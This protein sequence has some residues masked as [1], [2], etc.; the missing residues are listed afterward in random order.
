MDSW[1]I[2]GVLVPPAGQAAG[3][4]AAEV[5]REGGLGRTGTALVA[6][7]VDTGVEA[8][9]VEVEGVAAG[10]L[11]GTGAAGVRVEEHAATSRSPSMGSARRHAEVIRQQ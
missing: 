4:D 10:G 8:D 6:G 2:P 9:G 1:L 3:V 11:A 5:E 7:R